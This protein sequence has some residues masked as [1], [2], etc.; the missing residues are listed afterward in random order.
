M[1][2]QALNTPK[3]ANTTTASQIRFRAIKPTRAPSSN[4]TTP[5]PTT[6]ASL[7]LVPKVSM[8]NCFNPGGT[9]LM[10]TP[11]TDS[12]NDG[13]EPNRPAASSE[14]ANAL[15]AARAP[16]A[17]GRRRLNM[18]STLSGTQGLL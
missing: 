1:A 5:I 14:I 13:T 18:A 17:A 3:A 7:S 4:V 8:A 16:A 2:D 9:L 11:A 6:R 12:T 10:K 15:P